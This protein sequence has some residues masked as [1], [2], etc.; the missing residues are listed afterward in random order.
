[1][2]QQHNIGHA[3]LSK[4]QKNLSIHNNRFKNSHNT[5]EKSKSVKL[6]EMIK[7]NVSD[8]AKNVLDIYY[9]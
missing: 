4:L 9:Y 1:M 5:D 7:P 6:Y 3:V 8:K 2:V